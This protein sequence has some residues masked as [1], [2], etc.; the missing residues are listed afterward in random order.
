[1]S[2]S[3]SLKGRQYTILLL[4]ALS[5]PCSPD[6]SDAK[7]SRQRRYFYYLTG[8]DLPDCYFAYNIEQDKSVLFIPPIDPEEVIWSGLPLTVEQAKQQYV[9]S[10]NMPR[11]SLI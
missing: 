11:P 4:S 7:P 8:C 9:C 6:S 3:F 5:L 10:G 2:L 1:M